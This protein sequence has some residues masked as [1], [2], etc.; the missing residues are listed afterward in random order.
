MINNE[1]D[2][3]IQSSGITAGGM[4]GFLGLAPLK[5]NKVIFFQSSQDVHWKTKIQVYEQ[6]PCWK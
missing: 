5:L 2:T 4:R 3:Y 1:V 6:A